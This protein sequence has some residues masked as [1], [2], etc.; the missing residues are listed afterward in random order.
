MLFF[1]VVLYLGLQDNT[2]E[3]AVLY[4]HSAWQY[5]LHHAILRKIQAS[6]WTGVSQV[7]DGK[8]HVM[9]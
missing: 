6:M 4:T 7:R 2:R 9:E 1:E 3:N 8:L 5:M